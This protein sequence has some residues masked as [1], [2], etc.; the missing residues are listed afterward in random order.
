MYR[1]YDVCASVSEA[2]LPL[3]QPPAGRASVFSR[4]GRG[5]RRADRAFT[6]SS[7]GV[8]RCAALG[9]GAAVQVGV[10]DGGRA[11]YLPATVLRWDVPG[12][13]IEVARRRTPAHRRAGEYIFRRARARTRHAAFGFPRNFPPGMRPI[14]WPT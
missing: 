13:P 7:A 9:G 5:R 4:P 12:P 8:R 1:I 10:Y 11:A 3:P 2:P 6:R 14:G